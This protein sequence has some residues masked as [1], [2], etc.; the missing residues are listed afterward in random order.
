M[1][2]NNDENNKSES[3]KFNKEYE[4]TSIHN[5]STLIRKKY[6]VI[7]DPITKEYYQALQTWFELRATNTFEI[8]LAW[9]TDKCNEGNIFETAM[10]VA[11]HGADQLAKFSS[12][13]HATTNTNTNT[14]TRVSKQLDKKITRA[15][16]KESEKIRAYIAYKIIPDTIIKKY[17]EPLEEIASTKQKIKGEQF[18]KVLNEEP[19][20]KKYLFEPLHNIKKITTSFKKY[21]ETHSSSKISRST[22]SQGRQMKDIVED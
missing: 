6:K 7:D 8:F 18:H 2:N 22:L 19:I 1:I 10:N 14:D 5:E 12:K 21:I 17:K 20:L 3:E 16:I 15:D 9:L 11:F 4:G 13:L